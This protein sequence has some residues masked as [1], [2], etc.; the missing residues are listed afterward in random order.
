MGKNYI[1]RF[2]NNYTK[3]FQDVFRGLNLKVKFKHYKRSV[4]LL[5]RRVKYISIIIRH[6]CSLHPTKYDLVK[7]MTAKW[8]LRFNT[9]PKKKTSL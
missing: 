6:C 1:L 4:K 2:L 8:N 5:R 7:H 9:D 3:Q